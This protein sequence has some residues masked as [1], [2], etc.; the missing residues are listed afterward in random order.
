VTVQHATDRA[1]K[2]AGVG[3]VFAGSFNPAIFQ[4]AWFARHELIADDVDAAKVEAITPEFAAFHQ[5]WLRVAV[6]KDRCELTA[7]DAV[8]SERMLL[9]LA[10]GTFELLSETPITKLGINRMLHFQI[11]SEDEWH[12]L[13]WRLLPPDPWREVLDDPRMTDA[14]VQ[15]RRTSG[16]AGTT[17]VTVQ[18]SVVIHQGVFVSV[19]DDFP[20]ESEPDEIQGAGRAIELLGEVWDDSTTRSKA[21]LEVVKCL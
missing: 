8:G 12:A 16:P 11:A 15:S 5:D 7:S 9:D 4:P 17:F 18:P 20:I 14:S 10:V 19:N 2:A 3:V 6:V 13:G 21:I 1:S